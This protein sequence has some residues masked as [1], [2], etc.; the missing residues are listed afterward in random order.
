[1]RARS[2]LQA[3]SQ[4]TSAQANAHAVSAGELFKE[5]CNA[6]HVDERVG[7]Y[8]ATTKKL[9]TLEDFLHYFATPEEVATLVNAVPN[10][11]AE[12]AVPSPIACLHTRAPLGMRAGGNGDIEAQAGM[13]G[14]EKG[15]VCGRV[16]Q[17]TGPG[18][19]GVGRHTPRPRPHQ[20]SSTILHQARANGSLAHSRAKHRAAGTA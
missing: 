6:Y 13:G 4:R 2:L 8:L 14:R 18:R 10:I 19:E 16:E 9:R 20:H 15:R 3:D 17:E 7:V 11:P 12:E 1:M 5:L